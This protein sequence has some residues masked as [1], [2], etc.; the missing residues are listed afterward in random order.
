MPRFHL[1]DI[2][3]LENAHI[4]EDAVWGSLRAT[5]KRRSKARDPPPNLTL[6]EI[7]RAAINT[8]TQTWWL[9]TTQLCSYTG[10]EARGPQPGV[11]RMGSLLRTLR[12]DPSSSILSSLKGSQPPWPPSTCNCTRLPPSSQGLLPGSLWVL[13][14]II[15]TPGIGV[16]AHPKSRMPSS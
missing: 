15:R 12:W 13:S 3:L 9:H 8:S 7:P 4:R 10:L 14:L 11:S 2:S 1:C 16:G 5:G 6:H